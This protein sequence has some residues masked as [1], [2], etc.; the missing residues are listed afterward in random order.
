MANGD[1][2]KNMS[3]GKNFFQRG[4]NS[5]FSRGSQKYFSRWGE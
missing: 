3:I 4:F 5:G 2:F 1:V